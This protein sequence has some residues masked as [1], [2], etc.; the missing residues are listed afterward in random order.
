M[1]IAAQKV[2]LF[3][4][5]DKSE[6]ENVTIKEINN[7]LKQIKQVDSIFNILQLYVD[8]YKIINFL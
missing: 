3:A 4:I 2:Y 7:L 8:A 1:K 6:Q 5:Y